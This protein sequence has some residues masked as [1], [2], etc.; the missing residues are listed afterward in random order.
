M[1][2]MKFLGKVKEGAVFRFDRTSAKWGQ[3]YDEYKFSKDKDKVFQFNIVS[4]GTRISANGV[5]SGYGV[6]TDR[7]D[8]PDVCMKPSAVYDRH[9]GNGSIDI[10]LE[11]IEPI[12][13]PTD[14]LLDYLDSIKAKLDEDVKKENDRHC[15]RKDE[16]VKNYSKVT[17]ILTSFIKA[18]R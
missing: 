14:E 6:I 3:D 7:G 12:G 13:I 5:S 18:N 17:S 4:Y 1:S 10:D 16:L 8:I 11:S 2:E 15:K 9:Y